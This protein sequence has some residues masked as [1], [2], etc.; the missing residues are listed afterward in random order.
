MCPSKNSIRSMLF[1]P[2]VS[3]IPITITLTIITNVIRSEDECV[4]PDILFRESYLPL[5]KIFN[6]ISNTI[7][8][9]YGIDVTSN[10][11]IKLLAY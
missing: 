11:E 8:S 10:C 4:T 1:F 5:Y 2:E 7:S 6:D 3:D 9:T